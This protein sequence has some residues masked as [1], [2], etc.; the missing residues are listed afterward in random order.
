MYI[1]TNKWYFKQGKRIACLLSGQENAATFAQCI[2]AACIPVGIALLEQE[3]LTAL[4]DAAFRTQADP[5]SLATPSPF[6][7][8]AR[9][10]V[11]FFTVKRLGRPHDLGLLISM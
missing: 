9:V 7:L 1:A 11:H 5:G 10:C 4:V 3:P 6:M 8:H 2:F